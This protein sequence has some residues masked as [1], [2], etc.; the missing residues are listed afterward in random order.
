MKRSL[1]LVVVLAVVAGC[2][3]FKNTPQQDY[4]YAMARPCEGNGV[5]VKSVSPDGKSWSYSWFGGAYT[6]PEF[7]QC[8]QGQMRSNPYSQWLKKEAGR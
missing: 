4:L 5:Q 3:T 2:A 8:V 1:L 6:V 7:Q